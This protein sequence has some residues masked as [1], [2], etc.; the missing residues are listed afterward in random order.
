MQYVIGKSDLAEALA[1]E[2]QVSNKLAMQIVNSIFNSMSLKLSLGSRVVIKGFG[3][4][5]VQKTAPRKGFNP[6]TREPV[7]VPAG[8][9]VIFRPG[10]QLKRTVSSQ[11]PLADAPEHGGRQ[12]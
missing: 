1:L 5:C 11:R 12:Q 7:A 3:T 2:L 6:R 8:R 9:R 10:S 4:F